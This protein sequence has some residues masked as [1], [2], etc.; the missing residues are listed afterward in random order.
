MLVSKAGHLGHPLVRRLLRHGAVVVGGQQVHV[1]QPRS[2]QIPQVLRSEPVLSK[3]GV[4]APVLLGHPRVRDAELPNVQLI[5]RHVDRVAVVGVL[6]RALVPPALRPQRRVIHLHQLQQ[7]KLL[8]DAGLKVLDPN[9][10]VEAAQCWL[11]TAGISGGR[12]QC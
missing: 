9:L 12:W 5:D 1:G 6:R 11:R 10:G 8:V 7:V 4:L 2:P 3:G